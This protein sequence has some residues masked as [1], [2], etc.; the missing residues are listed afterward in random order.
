M[1]QDRARRE[2]EKQLLDVQSQLELERIQAQKM[3]DTEYTLRSQLSMVE[4]VSVLVL[5]VSGWVL[6][7]F[8]HITMSIYLPDSSS[9]ACFVLSVHSLPY[10][11]TQEL[12]CRESDLSESEEAKRRVEE[13]LRKTRELLR[14]ERQTWAEQCD[15]LKQVSN[16]LRH[17]VGSL[18][19]YSREFY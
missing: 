16:H 13:E 19:S 14:E 7:Y 1:T 12:S 18:R 15:G 11:C 5:G 6:A 9:S 2:S 4:E 8:A 10:P 3:K 17:M